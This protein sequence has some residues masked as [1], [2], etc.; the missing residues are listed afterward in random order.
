MLE[1]QLNATEDY[2]PDDY[3]TTEVRLVPKGC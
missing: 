1:Q 3:P 2:V